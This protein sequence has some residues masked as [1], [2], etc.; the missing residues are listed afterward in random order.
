MD[1]DTFSE[2]Y[3]TGSTRPPKSYGGV[4]AVLL[5]LVIF[6]S[7]VVT[8]LSVMNVRLF[9]LVEK[10]EA[11]ELL[12]ARCAPGQQA[13]EA[14]HGEYQQLLGITGQ[15]VTDFYQNYYDIPQGIYITWVDADSDCYLQGLRAGDIL[16]DCNETPLADM[17]QLGSFLE[18]YNTDSVGLTFYRA[19]K[20]H[21]ITVNLG[22]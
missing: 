9:R 7:G 10:Q 15:E 20:R 16:T 14:D 4:I 2:S 19:G 1:K 13:A 11:Q 22:E 3:R 17:Q 6:L 8:I 12:L 21:Q 18:T 5:I